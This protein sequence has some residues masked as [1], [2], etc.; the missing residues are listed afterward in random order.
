[1]QAF[2]GE[3]VVADA[4][5]DQLVQIEGNL[6]FPPTSV[7]WEHIEDSSTPYT[8]PWKG[9]A[10]YWNAHTST[11]HHSNIAWSYPAP[12]A[13]AVERVGIDFSGY[14]AFDTVQVRLLESRADMERN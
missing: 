10:Q 9:T 3:T 7:R 12:I 6:Y 2:I 5:E 1:M 4:P 11:G 8:C 14:M 13:S